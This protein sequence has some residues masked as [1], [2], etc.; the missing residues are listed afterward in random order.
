MT[1]LHVNDQPDMSVEEEQQDVEGQITTPF[2]DR[3]DVRK[4]E[5]RVNQT[6]SILKSTDFTWSRSPAGVLQDKIPNL[7]LDW[8]IFEDAILFCTFKQRLY[9]K[10]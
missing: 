5:I 3:E 4:R 8:S 2:I 9:G 10:F 7:G 1:A 6:L